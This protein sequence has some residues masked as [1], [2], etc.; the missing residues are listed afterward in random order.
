MADSRIQ[1]LIEEHR[2]ATDQPLRKD[3]PEVGVARV[4][5]RDDDD[6][7]IL[8]TPNGGRLTA[9]R[10]FNAAALPGSVVPISPSGQR[11]TASAVNHCPCAPTPGVPH[12]EELPLLLKIAAIAQVPIGD[13]EAPSRVGGH[14]SP[15][16]ADIGY[17]EFVS[18]I[19]KQKDEWIAA[20]EE[21]NYYWNKTAQAFAAYRF[22]EELRTSRPALNWLG[23][24]YFISDWNRKEPVTRTEST[25]VSGPGGSIVTTTKIESCDVE[26]V[27]IRLNQQVS[28][29][30]T[31]YFKRI[32]RVETPTIEEPSPDPYVPPTPV[33]ACT[34]T[35]KPAG[36]PQPGEKYLIIEGRLY[37]YGGTHWTSWAGEGTS[38]ATT[39]LNDF[40]RASGL[41]PGQFSQFSLDQIVQA[42]IKSGAAQAIPDLK[43]P[44][45]LGSGSLQTI[46]LFLYGI[47]RP[48]QPEEC[49]CP[50]S[51]APAPAP[52]PTPAPT[53]APTPGPTGVKLT[54]DVE[55]RLIFESVDMKTGLSRPYKWEEESHREATDGV[56]TAKT[57]SQTVDMWLPLVT[58]EKGDA[59]IAVQVS[60][61]STAPTPP[62]PTVQYWWSGPGATGFTNLD[63]AIF[64]PIFFEQFTPGGQGVIAQVRRPVP[65]LLTPEGQSPYLARVQVP[66]SPETTPDASGQ[67]MPVDFWTLPQGAQTTKEFQVKALQIDQGTPIYDYSF[68]PGQPDAPMPT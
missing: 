64:E 43:Q 22:W 62:P 18:K 35:C 29:S 14:T 51:P 16:P 33:P 8:E 58:N 59:V 15:R 46:H 61:T 49:T 37:T 57:Q 3:P 42:A 7:L 48:Y 34:P 47:G 19:G 40:C 17:G 38:F 68:H 27:A 44:G 31:Y 25:V 39:N 12:D 53:P 2:L 50:P 28:F 56:Q 63:R 41:F 55:F 67:R 26:I 54:E 1:R 36:P 23:Y 32:K 11:T 30:G 6:R 21:E 4:V 20:S 10:D 66:T 65:D 13:P 9:G 24:G 5:D 60:G 45:T 52:S